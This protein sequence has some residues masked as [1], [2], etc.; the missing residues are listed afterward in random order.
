MASPDL[1][2]GTAPST[3][4]KVKDAPGKLGFFY[5]SF[6][7]ALDCRCRFADVPII[8][9]LKFYPLQTLGNVPDKRSLWVGL[10]VLGREYFHVAT[11]NAI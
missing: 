4:E 6:C 1:N 11:A 5:G 7:E 9:A 8:I 2:R 10:L 3:P